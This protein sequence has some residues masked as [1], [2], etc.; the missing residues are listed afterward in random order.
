[1]ARSYQDRLDAIDAAMQ[2][3]EEGAQ[4]F[5]IGSRRVRAADYQALAKERERLQ[6]CVDA[7]SMEF[8]TLA[9]FERPS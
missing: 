2:R 1:M 6:Q 7:G 5:Y 8:A 9:Q 4:E 3:I